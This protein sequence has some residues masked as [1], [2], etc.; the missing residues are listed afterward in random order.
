MLTCEIKTSGQKSIQLTLPSEPE[1]Q[2][3]ENMILSQSA[4]NKYFEFKTLEYVNNQTI[5]MIKSFSAKEDCTIEAIRIGKKAII[6]SAIINGSVSEINSNE[7]TTHNVGSIGLGLMSEKNFH[8]TQLNKGGFFEKLNIIISNEDM[9]YYIERYPEIFARFK[10]VFISKKPFFQGVFE[11]TGK[12][13]AIAKE[14]ETSIKSGNYS[15]Q[16]IK[17][18]IVECF[19]CF[20][21]AMGEKIP[22][23]Y[24]LRGKIYTARHILIENFKSPPS[25]NALAAMSGT[26]ECTLKKVFKQEFSMTVF[27]Y[28]FEYRMKLAL[29]MLTDNILSINDIAT[30][31]GFKS[32]SHFSTVFKKK[33][34]TSPKEY[35]ERKE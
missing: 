20:L 32:Q 15:T 3:A 4:K 30:R 23:K 14:F 5:V 24:A 19:I 11:K 10:D 33:F 31:L 1:L 35:K 2:G 34:G 28:L 26:N 9:E 25:L 27:E 12:I 13:T 21:S 7:L 22:E 17:N 8:V 18:L 29:K 16:L 6:L